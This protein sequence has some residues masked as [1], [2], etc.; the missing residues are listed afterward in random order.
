MVRS[1]AVLGAGIMGS[2]TALH[3]ARRGANVTI[4]DRAQEPFSGASRWNEGK[5]HLGFLYAADPTLRTANAV[6][7]AGLDFVG[8]VERLT[9]ISLRPLTSASDDHYLIHRD[10]V[11]ETAA[12]RAYL[13]GVAAI[14]AAAPNAHRYLV[15][16]SNCSVRRLDAA[17]LSELCDTHAVKAG[18]RVPE[19]SVDTNAVADA[20]V[21]ALTSEPRIELAMAHAITK[22]ERADGV[23][24]WFVRSGRERHGPFDAVV[25]ALWE[26]R[27]QVDESAGHRPDTAIQHRY[28]VS[29]FARTRRTVDVPCAVLAVGPFGDV[30]NYTGRSFYLSWYPLGLLARSESVAPPDVPQLGASD[31]Q[32]IIAGTFEELSS[33]LPWVAEIEREAVDVRLAGGW[34]YSQGRGLLDDA[35]AS[36]HRRD[37]LGVTNCGSYFSVDTGKYSVA[38]TLADQVAR[39]VTERS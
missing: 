34:V 25:N 11:V 39:A 19:R 23:E 28:R 1:V 32:R 30:K 27:P 29:V 38:P 6:L 10:S 20:F 33:I 7:E 35:Q 5:I 37:R 18:F 16:V 24:Q 15:D 13:D 26:G 22:V 9:G 2:S 31:H 8:Q 3:L 14:V 4:F 36:V 17:E 21:D 12:A